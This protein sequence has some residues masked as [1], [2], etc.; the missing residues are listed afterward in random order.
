VLLIILSTT[1][2]LLRNFNFYVVNILSINRTWL[3]DFNLFLLQVF[4]TNYFMLQTCYRY[5][6]SY[7]ILVGNFSFLLNLR[8]LRR[9]D[10]F[11]EKTRKKILKLHRS[12]LFV[13]ST[14][15]WCNYYR[16]KF[17]QI[18]KSKLQR[19]DIIKSISKF[20]RSKILRCSFIVH[21]VMP[22]LFRHLIF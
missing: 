13:E 6:S 7:K 20:Y 16:M 12:D 21:N 5:A 1:R 15:K 19:S 14:T 18:K 9:S 10:L 4:L 11:V 3:Y 17:T 22:N 8:K 2:S